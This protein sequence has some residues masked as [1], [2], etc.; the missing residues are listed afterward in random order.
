MKSQDLRKFKLPDAPGVYIFRD[1]QKRPLYIGRATSLKDRTKSYFSIDLIDTRGPRIVDM[2]T[3]A[4]S[5]TWQETGS[6]LEAIILESALIKRYQPYYNVD[7]RDDKSA[8]YVVITE[9]EYPRVFLA[10]VRDFDTYRTKRSTKEYFNDG[11]KSYQIKKIYGPYVHSGL[12]KEALHI[13]RK[14]FP[15]RDDKSHDPRHETFYRTIGRSPERL[16]PAEYQ[17]TIRNLILFFEGKKTQLKKVLEKD[18]RAYAKAMAFEKAAQMKRLIYAI[19][20]VNDMALIKSQEKGDK[21]FEI[22]K[23]QVKNKS[24]LKSLITNISFRMEA[25]DIAHLSGT[26][27]VGAF[28]VSVNGEF[29]KNHYRKFILSKQENNDVQNLREILSRRLNHSE[30]QYPDLIIVDGGEAQLNAAKEVLSA[31]RMVIPV[32]GVVKDERHKAKVLIGDVQAIAG[33]SSGDMAREVVRLNAEAHRFAIT[34]HKKRRGRIS[35]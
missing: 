33:G 29:E 30:W 5:L 11:R 12:I 14:M 4:K 26:N 32:V 19:D 20:H 7:E 1:Y 3:K 23:S 25:Y 27:V 21:R 35:R 9:E 28:T 17:K 15:F 10:R 18:M 8:Q 16:V 22:R 24:N 6:V 13:L 2:V 34:F 31:R